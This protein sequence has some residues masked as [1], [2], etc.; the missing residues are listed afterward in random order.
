M[1]EELAIVLIVAA[2]VPGLLI[3]LFCVLPWLIDLG[4]ESD[5]SVPPRER[6]P[7]S[8]VRGLS[9]GRCGSASL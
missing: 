8:C 5:E 4:G 6:G 9:F 1:L 3:L 7:P 2:V